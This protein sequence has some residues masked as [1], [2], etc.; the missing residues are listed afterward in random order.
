MGVHD[1][2]GERQYFVRDN[3]AGF[4][5]RYAERLFGPFQRLHSQQEFDG[6]GI[7]LATVQ[8]I[9]H[10]HGGRAWGYGQPDRGATFY[11]TLGNEP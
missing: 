11:F 8:R 1:L 7:G 5:M 4:D 10:R 3:G 9:V 6:I 2:S